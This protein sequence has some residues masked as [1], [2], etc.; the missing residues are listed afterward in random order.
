MSKPVQAIIF[1]CFGVV[2]H[3]ALKA[4]C[5]TRLHQSML[6]ARHVRD[7]LAACNAG[8]LDP[9]EATG[10]LAAAMGMTYDEYV[11]YVARGEVANHVLLAYIAE[12]R[13]AY[14]I[15]MLS[16]VGKGSLNARIAKHDLTQYFDVIVVS[17]D[18]GVAKPD[19][20]AYQLI[21]DRLG[22][23]PSVCIF[24]D[25]IPAYCQGAQDA[26]MQTIQFHTTRQFKRDIAALLA[27]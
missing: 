14:K 19:I 18:V 3:D 17:G 27:T 1:D 15:G 2:I 10:Q 25:D 4:L 20:R 16:N 23:E 26:G 22:V 8:M 5:D 7:I 24:T 21:A 13:H 9:T 11:S 6:N 12:L